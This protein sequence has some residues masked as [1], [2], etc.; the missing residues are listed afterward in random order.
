MHRIVILDDRHVHSVGV[1]RFLKTVS[2][3]SVV[4]NGGIDVYLKI[5]HDL[6]PNLV[7]TMKTY[8]N[9]ER[10]TFED[11]IRFRSD[12]IKAKDTEAQIKLEARVGQALGRLMM[13]VENYPDLKANT[14]FLELQQRLSEIEVEENVWCKKFDSVLKQFNYRPDWYDGIENFAVVGFA[15]TFATLGSSPSLSASSVS[16]SSSSSDWSSGIPAA[17]VEDGKNNYEIK[18][19]IQK[20]NML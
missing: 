18:I 7:V 10:Q 12:A 19:W 20:H 16:T 11:I 1:K 5:R 2:D 4:G 13:V 8:A 6:V 17:E 3:F 9:R 15:N 14:N